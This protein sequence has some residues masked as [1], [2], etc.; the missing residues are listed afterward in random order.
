MKLIDLIVSN[1]WLSI[2]LTILK[3]YPKREGEIE[4]FRIVFEKLKYIEPQ[5]N[6]MKI[7]LTERDS[8]PEFDNDSDT[9]VDVSGEN[10]TINEFGEEISY[11]LEFESWKK[12]LG[13]NIA[14]VTL[15]NFT[16][17]EIISHCLHEMT[18]FGYD[19]SD[20]NE[21]KLALD[22][23]VDEFN[24]LTEEAREKLTISHEHVI[25][26]LTHKARSKNE[27]IQL[28]ITLRGTEPPIWRRIQVASD[29]S[30]FELHHIIQL[31]MGWENYH[32]FQFKIK[33][34]FYGM[35]EHDLH[36]ADDRIIDA[37]TIRLNDVLLKPKQ[38][39]EYEYDFGDGWKHV[40]EFEKNLSVNEKQNY[41]FCLDGELNC[42]PEDIGGIPGYYFMIDVLSKKRHPEKKH[43]LEWLGG[44]YDPKH[45]DKE[46]VNAEFSTLEDYINDWFDENED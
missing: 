33:N 24:K 31:A 30:L 35:P 15:K 23:Q 45:F 37:M 43:L 38:K 27:I 18:F 40:I 16:E 42:P 4:E 32:L 7:V 26:K 41:P 10:G 2:E 29:I 21:Q 34:Y 11:A 17:L 12:W 5:N 8:D 39:F 3:L 25:Q 46:L 20:I 19:E 44:N 22:R 6:S 36:F 28:K 14:K 9:Y 1:S 13:M